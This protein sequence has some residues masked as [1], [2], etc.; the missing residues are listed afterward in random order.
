MLQ[1]YNF[2]TLTALIKNK[3]E[4]HLLS[5]VTFNPWWNKEVNEV[6]PKMKMK[7]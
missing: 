2:Y 7:I 5:S 4:K 3:K 1:K 6:M